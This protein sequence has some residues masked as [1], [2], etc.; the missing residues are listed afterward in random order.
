M[1][2]LLAGLALVP[3]LALAH[4]GPATASGASSHA[5]ISVMGDHTHKQGEWMLSYRYMQMNM[6]G[7]L[8]GSDGISTRQ[9]TGT[10]IAP[11]K[12]MVAPE[13]MTMTMHMLGAMYAP[14]DDLT[15]MVMLPWVSTEMD[16]VTRMGAAFT[17]ETEGVGD[18][19]ISGLV[20]VY[21]SPDGGHKVHLNLGLSLPTGSIDERDDTPAMANAKL[22]YSMQL[23]SGS[24]DLMPGVTYR[25]FGNHYSWGLQARATLPTGEND[26]DYQLGNRYGVTGWMARSLSHALSVSLGLQYQYWNEIDGARADLNPM[27]VPTADPNAYGGQRGDL[28]VGLNYLFEKG[29]LKGHRLALEYS[30]PVYQRLD[31]PQM[32]AESTL[33]LGWQY[34]F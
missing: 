21:Q 2:I 27:M 33:T 20:N 28:S 26:N 16:H 7:N 18:V 5:P 30:Q 29:A 9:I 23:G 13:K 24:V 25:G 11:G 34:A 8:D 4:G 15:L 6:D 19:K 32:E 1:K 31:G 3:G 17:T 12:Y 22:P 14:S 10:M